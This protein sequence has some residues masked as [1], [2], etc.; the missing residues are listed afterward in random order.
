MAEIRTVTTLRYRRAEIE[1][2]TTDY[3]KRIAQANGGPGAH[4]PGDLDLRSKLQS[5]GLPGL[6]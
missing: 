6:R 5:H 1:K 2:A 4:Q 3:E